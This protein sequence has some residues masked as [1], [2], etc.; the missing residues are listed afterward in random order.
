MDY[1]N[2]KNP[3]FICFKTGSKMKSTDTEIEKRGKVI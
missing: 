1:C 3:G 2:E